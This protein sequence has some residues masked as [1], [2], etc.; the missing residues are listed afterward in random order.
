MYYEFILVDQTTGEKRYTPSFNLDLIDQKLST[1]ITSNLKIPII[2]AV[3]KMFFVLDSLNSLNKSVKGQKRVA[4][5]SRQNTSVPASANTP[6]GKGKRTASR[7]Q[8]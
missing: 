4:G 8:N 5:P 1:I 6:Q 7:K 2:I 3:S